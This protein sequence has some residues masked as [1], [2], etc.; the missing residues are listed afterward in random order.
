MDGYDHKVGTFGP[1][2]ESIRDNWVE[3]RD[4]CDAYTQ[5]K[6]KGSPCDVRSK[7]WRG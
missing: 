4:V 2:G 3:N 5:C 1:P 6:L 7:Y